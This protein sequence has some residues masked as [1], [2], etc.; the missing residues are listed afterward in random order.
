MSSAINRKMIEMSNYYSVRKAQYVIIILETG[1]CQ[2]SFTYFSG[3]SLPPLQ[4]G[5]KLCL[6]P[7]HS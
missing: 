3:V 6:S 7:S 2:G 1:R 4:R 5:Q